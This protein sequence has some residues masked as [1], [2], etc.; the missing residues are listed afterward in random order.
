MDTE[1]LK[2]FLARYGIEL[3]WAGEA[4]SGLEKLKSVEPD[5]VL[6]DVMLPRASGIDV[7]R[8][9]RQGAT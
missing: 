8:Q 6:L 7:C 1:L 9:L 4:E 3:E 2:T 5:L